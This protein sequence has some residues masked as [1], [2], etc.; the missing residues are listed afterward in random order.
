MKYLLPCECGQ[1]TSIEPSQA[2]QKIACQ[3]GATLVV[4][5]MRAVR[6]LEPDASQPE[7][8]SKRPQWNPTAGLIFA[9]GAFFAMLGILA[10]S[11]G[12]YQQMQLQMPPPPQEMIDLW[13]SEID[14]SSPDRLWEIWNETLDQGLG[15]Y[16]ASPF[17]IVRRRARFFQRLQWAGFGVAGVGLLILGSAAFFRRRD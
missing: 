1:A 13:I 17:I 3:C 7:T 8:A 5:S 14:A 10:G 16:N 12:A 6:E 9:V 4:P 11:F 15:D 2:G